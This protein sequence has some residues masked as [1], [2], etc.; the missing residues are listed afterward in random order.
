MRLLLALILLLW[1]AAAMAREQH[2]AVSL[3]TSSDEPQAGG[4]ITFGLRFQPQPGWHGYWTNPGDSGLAPQVVWS[5]SGGLRFGPLRHPAPT[6]LHVAGIT[7]FVH[8][9]SHVLLTSVHVPTSLGTGS[10]VPASAAISWLACSETLCVPEHATLTVVLTVGTGTPGADATL[11]RQAQADL[12]KVV[13]TPIPFERRGRTLRMPLPAGLHLQGDRTRFFPDRNGYFDASTARVEDGVLHASLSGSLPAAIT[14]VLADGRQAYRVRLTPVVEASSDGKA[15]A[16]VPASTSALPPQASQ[17]QGAQPQ[18]SYHDRD[19]AGRRALLPSSGSLI[20]PPVG[21]LAVAVLLAL[22]GGLL[23]NLMPCVFPILSLKALGLARSDGTSGEAR[24]EA[25]GYT[26]GALFGTGALGLLLVVLQRTG[27]EIGWSFQL[28]HPATILILFLLSVAITF[29]LAGIFELPAM[30]VESKRTPGAFASGALAAFVA[31]PC[32]GPFM[33]AA[34]GSAMLLPIGG[35]LLVFLALGLGL[36]LPF[37][38]I[39]FVPPVRRLLPR[40]G[41]WMATFRRILALPM[42]ATSV[43]LVWLIGRQGGTTAMTLAIGLAAI[44]GTATW[45]MGRRQT[46]ERP[47]PWLPLL[48]AVLSMT[49]LILASPIRSA[50]FVSAPTPAGSEPFS[51]ARLA[52]LRREGRPVFV[53]FTADWCLTCKVNEK[54]AIDRLE[55]RAAFDRAGVITLRGDWTTGAPALTRFLAK[56]GRNSIPFYLFVRPGQR[57]ELLPQLLTPTMLIERADARALTIH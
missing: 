8:A 5:A 12:P 11:I 2:I 24:V 17:E 25:M 28:Q 56:N 36:S 29:N 39:A 21:S 55:T 34:L 13:P 51:E 44:L 20:A 27:M 9:G 50:D 23:L 31:T 33:A 45:W 4:T 43:A 7:S 52:E 14:G 38:V 16:P 18:V 57:P 35:A 15:P 46:G 10:S 6:I 37:L 30:S 40:P 53:D 3:L 19:D 41:P 42:L 26:A 47:R 54:M 32:S 48:P 1:P 49:L 22:L